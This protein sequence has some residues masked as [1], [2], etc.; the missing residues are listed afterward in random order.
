MSVLYPFTFD[1]PRTKTLVVRIVTREVAML[2]QP[3]LIVT[4]LGEVYL[5]VKAHF[6]WI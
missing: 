3:M 2:Y 4:T 6:E 5:F 1:I